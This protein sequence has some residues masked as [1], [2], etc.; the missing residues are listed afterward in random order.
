MI[1]AGILGKDRR[2]IFDKNHSQALVEN[3]SRLK[4][5][6][7]K[8]LLINHGIGYH[9]AGMDLSDRN[10]IENCF[11]KGNLLVLCKFFKNITFPF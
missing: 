4:D 2:Y 5:S 3:A 1:S 11:L 10:L 9:H 8:E 7:L 6:K